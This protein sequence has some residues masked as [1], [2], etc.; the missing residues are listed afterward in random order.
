[1][2]R[3]LALCQPRALWQPVAHIKYVALRLLGSYQDDW[4]ILL[5]RY[6]RTLRSAVFPIRRPTGVG[7]CHKLLHGLSLSEVIL[8]CHRLSQNWIKVIRKLIEKQLYTKS[9]SET[10]LKKKLKRKRCFLNWS[11]K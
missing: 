5:N 1:M 9:Q 8:V 2:K 6:L 4:F 7:L 3:C 10:D 11:P